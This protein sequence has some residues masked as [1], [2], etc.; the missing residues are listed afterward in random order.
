MKELLENT[1]RRALSY[2]ES[3]ETRSVAPSPEA[4]AS[5]STLER[6]LPETATP[7]EQVI[8]ML[9]EVCSPATTAMAGPRFFGLVIG[10][11]LPVTLAANWLACAWDQNTG[12]FKPTPATAQLEQVALRWL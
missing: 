9:D 6:P 1:T 4:V 5:L 3:L 11:A 2:L 12:L 8:K 7:P 10:G